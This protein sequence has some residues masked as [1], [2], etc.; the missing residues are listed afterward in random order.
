MTQDVSH[1]EADK[2]ATSHHLPVKSTS[3]SKQ[4]DEVTWKAMIVSFLYAQWAKLTIVLGILILLILVFLIFHNVDKSGS[5]ESKNV[6]TTEQVNSSNQTRETPTMRNAKQTVKSVVTVENENSNATA[7][8][9]AAGD[10]E[11]EIGSG[12]VYN[13]VNN[14]IYIM[15]NAHVVGKHKNQKITYGDKQVTTGKVIGVDRQ[16]DMAVVKAKLKGDNDVQAIEIGDSN[17]LSLGESIIVVGNPLGV[18]F[19]GSVTRGI[20]SGLNRN[21]PLDISNDGKYDALLNV[22]QVDAP[23]NPGNS[24][25][26]VVDE[27]GKLI[28]ITSLKIDMKNVEGMAFAIPINEA[29]SLAKELERNGKINYPDTGVTLQNV[30]G[31]SPYER[32]VYK[33]PEKVKKGV[34]VKKTKSKSPAEKSG[35]KNNDIIVELDGKD[36]DD[37][38]K[39]EQIIRS[40]RQTTKP[41][42]MKIYRGGKPKEVTIKL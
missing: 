39:Y 13:K 28:G 25:G 15:T 18:D 7:T 32:H 8:N 35:L 23:V 9:Q 41:I 20:V 21:V 31:L 4:E 11:N 6:N 40:H 5:N 38:L 29:R 3:A 36:V 37:D 19:R 12:V 34:V 1:D 27:A 24:G 42:K 30:G 16:S 33:V 14:E 10:T 26:A 22:I 17:N 2:E